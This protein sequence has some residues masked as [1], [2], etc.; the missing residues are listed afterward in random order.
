MSTRSAI[1]LVTPNTITGI[2]CHWDGYPSHQGPILTQYYDNATMVRKLI[3]LGNLSILG[4]EI[5]RKHNF[6]NHTK[7]HD[8]WCLAYG[9]DRGEP[10]QQAKTFKSLKDFEDNYDWSEY[11]Y[12]FST[13]RWRYKASGD[14]YYRFLEFHTEAA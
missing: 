14:E 8:E 5:G 6:D 4:K 3:K 12:I 10:D 7:E 1:A 13:G 9:R 2:Y 11:Y